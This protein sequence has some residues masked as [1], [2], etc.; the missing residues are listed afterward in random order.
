MKRK[1]F[2]M[3]MICMIAGALIAGGS[4]IT[5]LGGQEATEKEEEMTEVQGAPS[6]ED[7]E[8][9]E[10]REGFSIREISG[11]VVMFGAILLC[12]IPEKK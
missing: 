8:Q 2:T 5:T 4:G 11:C 1:R 7:A 3:A 6:T 12:T 9:R 10:Y